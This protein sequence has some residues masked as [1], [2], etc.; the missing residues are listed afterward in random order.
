MDFPLR[1]LTILAYLIIVFIIPMLLFLIPLLLRFS[2]LPSLAIA[3]ATTTT[4][5]LTTTCLSI[6]KKTPPNIPWAGL[7]NK[8]YFPKL[9]ASLRQFSAGRKPLEEGFEKVYVPFLLKHKTETRKLNLLHSTPK[10]I[11][12]SYS[13]KSTNPKS[14]SLP[15]MRTG[16]SPNPNPSSP[17]SQCKTN[18][19]A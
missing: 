18:S 16:S 2:L 9:R 7:E 8:K 1:L 13:P 17:P 12:P 11:S 3:C 10:T 19:L 14:S 6:Y 15:Q 4:L 5:F